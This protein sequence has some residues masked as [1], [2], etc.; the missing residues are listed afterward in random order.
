MW[1]FKRVITA[2]EDDLETNG[3]MMTNKTEMQLDR[4]SNFC[5]LQKHSRVS[6]AVNNSMVQNR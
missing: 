5:G 1:N 3:A 6:M 2:G 4:K